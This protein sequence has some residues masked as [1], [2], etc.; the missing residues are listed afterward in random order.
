MHKVVLILFPFHWGTWSE[1]EDYHHFILQES[2][3]KGVPQK[4]HSRV[5]PQKASD[6]KAR[7]KLLQ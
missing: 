5:S 6:S 7:L 1:I 4:L 2:A 3:F